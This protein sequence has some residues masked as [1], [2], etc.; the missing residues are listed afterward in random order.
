MHKSFIVFS[1]LYTCTNWLCVSLSSPFACH[2]IMCPLFTST[3]PQPNVCEKHEK[4]NNWNSK[5]LYRSEMCVCACVCWIPGKRQESRCMIIYTNEGIT[6]SVLS[7]AFFDIW[8]RRGAA[9]KCI[10]WQFDRT[11]QEIITAII[12][13]EWFFDCCH[14]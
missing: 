9:S 8:I 1:F 3:L 5:L 14:P 7:V 4:W 2:F 11:M 6:N 10:Q 13:F 12:V